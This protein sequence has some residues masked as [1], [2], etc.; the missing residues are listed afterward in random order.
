MKPCKEINY[1]LYDDTNKCIV[2]FSQIN[3][4]F[5]ASV[6]CTLVIKK[7]TMCIY[8]SIL[9]HIFII[10]VASQIMINDIYGNI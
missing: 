7:S 9:Y 8:Y 5:L 1:I 10:N 6:Q 2:T 3:L 4:I